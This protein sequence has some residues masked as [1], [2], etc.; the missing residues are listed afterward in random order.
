MA[1][2]NRR[3]MTVVWLMLLCRMSSGRADILDP[4]RTVRACAAVL[5]ALVLA[6][7]QTAVFAHEVTH[8]G[9]VVELKIARYAQPGGGAREVVELE[10]MVVDPKTRKAS[11]RVFTITDK[12][13]ILRASKPVKVADVSARKDEKVAVVVD[14]DKPGDDAIEVRFEAAR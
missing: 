11:N 1:A 7:V 3:N 6:S 10:V 2:P 5:G 13:R 12:T 4:M 14:H 9:T 8:T